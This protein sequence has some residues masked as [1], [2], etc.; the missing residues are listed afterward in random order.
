M[1]H[2]TSGK[3]TGHS[4]VQCTVT[5]AGKDIDVKVLWHGYLAGCIVLWLECK[6]L[7]ELDSS[8]RWN[9]VKGMN[10][11]HRLHIRLVT[12]VTLLISV[13][14]GGT[15]PCHGVKKV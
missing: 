6:R 15:E 4:R 1:L 11:G 2:D 10:L 14:H 3:V 8:L 12:S 13:R 9:D 7:K 5:T